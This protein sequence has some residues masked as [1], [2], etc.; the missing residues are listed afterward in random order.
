MSFAHVALVRAQVSRAHRGAGSAKDGGGGTGGARGGT[1]CARAAARDA[2]C[3]QRRLGLCDESRH[4]AGAA[5][6]ASEGPTDGQE[7]LGMDDGKLHVV[8]DVSAAVWIGPRL[9]GAFGAVTRT[10]PSGFPAYARICHPAADSAGTATNWREVARATGRQAHPLMQ[11]HLL[12]GSADPVNMRGSVWDGTDPDRGNLA[13]PM[14]AVLC[15]RL[16]EHTATGDRCFFGL[17]EGYGRLETYGWTSGSSAA[18]SD[19]SRPGH[20][21]SVQELTRPRL[22][23]AGRGYLVLAGALRDARRV[24]SWVGNRPDPQSPNFI[25]PRDRAW[26]VASEVDFDSTLVG[27]PRTLIEVILQNPVLDAWPVRP[28]DSLAADADEINLLRS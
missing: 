22:R 25:W 5:G 11:W 21:F 15:D 23:L 18:C 2:V 3:R 17:W 7:C 13:A 9:G 26:C 24:C 6:I 20:A 28:G 19:R 4:G 14:L 1:A 10:V 8:D 12:V 27:G 16:A